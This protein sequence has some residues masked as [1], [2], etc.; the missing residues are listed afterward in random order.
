MRLGFIGLGKMGLNM[1]TR[2]SRDGH[3]VYATAR[4]DSHRAEAE[5]AG[6]R[7]AAG[8][9]DFTS[10]LSSPR[11][12]WLMVPAGETTQRVLDSLT[13]VL[14]PGDIIIDGGNSDY[15]DT[16]I[17]NREITNRG[18][19]FIDSG[20]SGCIWGL[21]KGYCLMIGGDRNVVNLVSP[22]FKTLACHEG[23]AHVGKP[24]SGHYV[25]M[26]HNA[27]EYGMMQS[28]AEGF[29]LLEA[30]GMNLDHAQIA[31]LWNHGSVVRSWLMELSESIFSENSSLEGL[32]GYVE[33]NGEC[34]WA[35]ET[36]INKAVPAPVFA[37]SLFARYASRKSDAFSNRYLAALRNKFGGHS[38]KKS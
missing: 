15:R 25:K 2:L 37:T 26:I 13:E 14:A 4:T 11:I 32:H 22:L 12:V 20:T 10:M 19:H 21:E 36:A 34:R 1:V 27:I 9:E 6:A 23:W 30:S 7:W 38:V 5:A 18:I 29:E 28:M 31:H 17:R 8:I 24:G 35:V 16:V 3:E 33:D